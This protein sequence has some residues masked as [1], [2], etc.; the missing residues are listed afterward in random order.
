MT[1]NLNEQLAASQKIIASQDAIIDNQRKQIN[2]LE[3][4][5]SNL[6]KEVSELRTYADALSSDYEEVVSICKDQQRI[7]NSLA[8]D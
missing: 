5:K 1:Q 3:T 7:L 8:K 2:T 4:I 6:E